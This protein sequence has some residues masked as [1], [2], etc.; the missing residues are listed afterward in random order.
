MDRVRYG[1]LST[2]QVARNQ[3]IPAA[4]EAA[5]AEIV[6]IS[7]R[8][9]SRA[10]E[11]ASRLE[12]PRAYGSYGEL[13]ADPGIDAVIVPL[14]NSLHCEWTVKAVEAGKHVLCEKPLA[15]TVEEAR[16][17]ID[18]AQANGVLLMEAFTTRF[19]PVMPCVRETIGSG[20]I[21]E[22]VIVRA[23]LTYTIQDW[24]ADNRVKAELGGGALLDAGCY[25]VNAIRFVMGAEPESV[26]AFQREKEGYGVDATFVGLMRFPGDRMACMATGMEQPFRARCEVI[27]TAGRIEVPYL[28]GEQ[29]VKVVVGGQERVLEF[30]AVNRFRAQIAHFADCILHGTQPT[31]PPEDGLNNTRVLVALQRAAREGRAVEV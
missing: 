13:L 19:Q 28:F 20:Q 29:V 24:D 31:L 25:C 6:A 3:H 26:Q 2:S 11:W 27:G 15:V 5:N 10:E 9:R 30:D 1:V 23:E 8:E 18:A 14:P 7:S 22:V 16:R 21:G 17:M 4:R 12:I